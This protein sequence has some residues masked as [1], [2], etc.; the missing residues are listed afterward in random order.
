MAKSNKYCFYHWLKSIMSAHKSLVNNKSFS[1]YRR[2]L[3]KEKSSNFQSK[4]EEPRILLSE[5]FCGSGQS[6]PN[7]LLIIEDI[8]FQNKVSLS[9]YLCTESGWTSLFLILKNELFP[10]IYIQC[11]WLLEK[12][13]LLN[14]NFNEQSHEDK[15]MFSW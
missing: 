3:K 5:L 4:L 2:V 8:R 7:I 1:F 6:L 10:N 9:S 12:Q 11:P 15:Y 14:S 13:S